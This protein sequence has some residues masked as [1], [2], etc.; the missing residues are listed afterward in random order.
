MVGG[1][2]T[3]TLCTRDRPCYTGGQPITGG[4]E[5][6]RPRSVPVGIIGSA[7]VVAGAVLLI[8]FAPSSRKPGP[9]PAPDPAR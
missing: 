5:E 6:T 2:T 4:A 3:E 1:F 7:L 8:A 9:V